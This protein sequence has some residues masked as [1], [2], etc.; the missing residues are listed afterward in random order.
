MRDAFVRT[1]L[2]E[3]KRDKDV[4][5]ITGDLGF[6]VLEK[7]ESELPSQFINAGVAEQSMLGLAAGMASTGKRVFVY[8]IGNF[9]TIRALEQIRNDI[10]YMNN[11]VVIVAV[12]SGYSYGSQGYTH[13]ALEDIAVMRALPNMN[14]YSPADPLETELITR[15]LVKNQ[16]PSYLR[17]GRSGERIFNRNPLTLENGRF[18]QIHRGKDG[19]ILFT[20]SI[21]SNV[22]EARDFLL[23]QGIEVGV[24]SIPY[25][26]SICKA[27]LES[28]DSTK[29]IISV[30]EH[31][32]RGGLTS[33]LLER[34]STFRLNIQ[35]VPVTAEQNN[36]SNIGD[37]NY[38]RNINGLGVPQITS[39]FFQNN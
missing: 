18:N 33:A 4:V 37:Q 7:F 9:P 23:T 26:S 39:Y 10:C 14:V 25:I 22:I 3:A 27:D 34:I 36:L 20:G 32:I 5:L 12:G 38:L 35:I 28:L 30:E 6:G 16:K 11:S 17:L 29:P 19:T 15:E 31:T 1:L 13:H 8:S 21:G 24:I 2:D